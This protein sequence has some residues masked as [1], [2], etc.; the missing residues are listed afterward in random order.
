MSF[1]SFVSCVISYTSWQHRL[2]D[3]NTGLSWAPRTTERTTTWKSLFRLRRVVCQSPIIRLSLYRTLLDN[4]NCNIHFAGCPQCGHCHQSPTL[5][6]PPYSDRTRTS[7]MNDDEEGGNAL[8]EEG[9]I[10]AACQCKIDF[11]IP[12][13]RPQL[14]PNS[15]YLF[16]HRHPPSSL[17]RSTTM[18]Q[19]QEYGYIPNPPTWPPPF[20]TIISIYRHWLK[21]MLRLIVSFD[22]ILVVLSSIVG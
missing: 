20:I 7:I 9:A 8:Q 15:I 1:L 19:C 2:I 10:I 17:L 3:C 11:Y 22:V 21:I 16:V 14:L 13:I 12:Y 18:P 5:A 6:C 4:N